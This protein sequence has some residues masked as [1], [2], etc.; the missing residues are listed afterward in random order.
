MKNF[1]GNGKFIIRNSMFD[2]PQFKTTRKIDDG[3]E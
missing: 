2:I 1:E 3:L